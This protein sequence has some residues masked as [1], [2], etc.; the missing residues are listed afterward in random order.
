[1]YRIDERYE[2]TRVRVELSSVNKFY[3]RKLCNML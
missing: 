2:I 1:M 3:E